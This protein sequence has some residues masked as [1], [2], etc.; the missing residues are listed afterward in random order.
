MERCALLGYV[1]IVAATS[2]ATNWSMPWR[3]TGHHA[4]A[5]DGSTSE[6]ATGF[7]DARGVAID[8]SRR[9]LYVVDRAAAGANSYLRVLPLR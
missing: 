7:H 5:P 3:S 1:P 8:S 2:N 4:I 9:R 6:I